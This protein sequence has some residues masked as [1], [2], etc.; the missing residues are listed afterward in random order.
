MEALLGKHTHDQL[1][2]TVDD[3]NDSSLLIYHWPNKPLATP[4]QV[5]PLFSSTSEHQLSQW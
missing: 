5:Q 1:F 2:P 3:E 4:L